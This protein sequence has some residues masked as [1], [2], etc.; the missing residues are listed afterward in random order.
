MYENYWQAVER[1][2]DSKGYVP[3]WF[4]HIFLL[5]S[6]KGHHKKIV[7]NYDTTAVNS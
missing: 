5:K 2:V 4:F 3:V 6:I 7:F 1:N